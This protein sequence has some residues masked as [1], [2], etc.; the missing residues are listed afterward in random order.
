MRTGASS[1]SYKIH[2][3]LIRVNRFRGYAEHRDL[4]SGKNR[5]IVQWH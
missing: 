2:N 1:S 3:V 4:A 5:G